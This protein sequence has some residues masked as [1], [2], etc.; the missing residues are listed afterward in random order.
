MFWNAVYL[1]EFI[2]ASAGKKDDVPGRAYFRKLECFISHHYEVGD[3]YMEYTS[4]SCKKTIGNWQS[5]D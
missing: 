3:L 2:K 1:D 5:L 4:G